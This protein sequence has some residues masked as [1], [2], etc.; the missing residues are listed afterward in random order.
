MKRVRGTS[1]SEVMKAS[2]NPWLIRGADIKR[3]E[4]GSG[5]ES[6]NN[7]DKRKLKASQGQ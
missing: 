2:W 3:E 4:G 1:V 7:S 5:E 6:G